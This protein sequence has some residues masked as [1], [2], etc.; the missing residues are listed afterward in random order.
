MKRSKT[1]ERALGAALA[2]ILAGSTLAL[3][4]GQTSEAQP[5]VKDGSGA[6]A[7]DAADADADGCNGPNGCGSEKENAK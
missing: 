4:C 7:K 6:Q 2:G 5:A 1:R 3:A